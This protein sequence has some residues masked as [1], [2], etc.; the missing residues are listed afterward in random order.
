MGGKSK[1]ARG[2]VAL[3]RGINVGGKNRLPMAELVPL[4]EAA[5]CTDVRSYIQS[6]NVL[7]NASPTLVRVLAEVIQAAIRTQYG[8]QV[9]LVLRAAD[10]LAAIA[11]QN[12]FLR[13]G[14][15]PKTLHLMCLADM[16]TSAQLAKLDATRSAPDEFRVHGDNIYLYLPNGA[17]RSKLSTAYFDRTLATTS[18]ARNWNT[19]RKLI[20]LA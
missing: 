13:P 15:D 20:E 8:Y 6:G 1:G 19:V 5:G 7:F 9:P 17:A 11:E 4:F 10:E 16:P 2:Y 14:R 12:P 18:T 3:M